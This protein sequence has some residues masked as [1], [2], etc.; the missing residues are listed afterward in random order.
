MEGG[1]RQLHGSALT[2]QGPQ[3]TVEM[4]AG[5]VWK[6]VGGQ[7]VV[8]AAESGSLSSQ[9]DPLACTTHCPAG[10]GGCF[11]MHFDSDMSLDMRRITAVW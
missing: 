8:A 11:P 2:R 3:A 5:Q 9:P 10:H 1:W 6:G 4:D 7:R